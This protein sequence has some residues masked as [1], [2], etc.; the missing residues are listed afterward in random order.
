MRV[1]GTHRPRRIERTGDDSPASSLWGFVW[2]MT[3]RAQ[4]GVI[5]L[6][7]VATLVSLAPI[8]L[9]RRMV[10]DALPAGDET[11]L[12]WLG[13][14]YLASILLLQALKFVIGNVTGWLAE[15]TSAYVRA[16][17]WRLRG[18]D[19]AKDISSVLLTEVD[20]L[21]GFA[22]LAPSQ[23]CANVA[24]LVGALS[25][26]F[27]VEPMV[28]LA[29]LCLIAPQ[30][31]LTPAIQRKLN[32]YVSTRVRLLR[33]FSASLEKGPGLKGDEMSSRLGNLFKARMA[34]LWWKFLMK[35][36]LNT[37]NAA[38]PLAVILVGGWM[39]IDGDTT[40][41]VIIAFV[42]GF[43]RLG[44]PI[45]QLIAFYREAAEATVRHNLLADWMKT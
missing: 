29:G 7:I 31:A 41:G 35:A 44:D 25:Y 19:S 33:R 34:L 32:A 20:A 43:S 24:M 9:Q 18:G 5:A 4:L 27:W 3:G 40:V 42:T 10:D 13:G 22:G 38:A 15:S 1:P 39:A 28:A 26:M 16:H 30:A 2:R 11:L 17:L 36:A 12:L 45:R 6:A 21:S 14:V 8:E 37:L 23:F